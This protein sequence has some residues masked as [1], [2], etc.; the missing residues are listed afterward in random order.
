M[1]HFFKDQKIIDYL[2]D[3][4]VVLISV[5][6]LIIAIVTAA[7]QIPAERESRTIFP[8][9]AKPV[10]RWQMVL[11]K[12]FGC[13]F[14]SGIALLVFYVFF[15]VTLGSREQSWP[16]L[17]YLQSFWLQWVQLGIVTA[18]ALSG[19]IVFAAPSST[20][21]ICLIFVAGILLLGRHLNVVA[22]HHA[23]P[24][25]S[26]IYTVYYLIP[27]LE[28]FDVR[29]RL[30]YNWPLARWSDCMLATLLRGGLYR[31]FFTADLAGIPP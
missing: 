8:L 25:R 1:V 5:S 22:L 28:W 13:W 2:K 30:T 27:H 9:L 6:V 24:L 20:T 12:F 10:T 16:V 29:D 11:G 19:S 17:N 3:L 23:E 15:A 7:R 14:A 4:C 31:I 26:V 21:T 18:I